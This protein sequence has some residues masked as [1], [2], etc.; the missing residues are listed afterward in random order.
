MGERAEPTLSEVRLSTNAASDAAVRA[1]K[2]A[3][4]VVLG[5][6]NPITSI[7]A[8]LTLA[9]MKEAIG[10]APLRIAVS[11]VVAEVESN[12]PGVRH[13]ALARRRALATFGRTDTPGAIAGLYAGVTE[14]FVMDNADA[15]ETEE[16][17]RV[18]LKPVCAD[19]LDTKSLAESLVNLCR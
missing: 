6:S 12:D 16:V 1:I 5:P 11:P 4:A 9:G 14:L 13:H 17:R 15:G 10:Y 3:D 19:L 8:I 2:G 18:G 7:G